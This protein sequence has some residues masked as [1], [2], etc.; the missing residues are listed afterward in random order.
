[1]L[2][3]MPL[4]IGDNVDS[5]MKTAHNLGFDYMEVSLD[6]PL[7]YVSEFKEKL[8]RLSEELDLNLAFHAPWTGLQPAH[9]EKELS[10]A[11]LEV[12]KRAVKF[13]QFL[14][15]LYFN[16][17]LTTSYADAYDHSNARN[18]IIFRAGEAASEISSFLKDRGVAG[19]LENACG[20]VLS[21]PAEF[22]PVLGDLGFCYDVGHGIEKPGNAGEEIEEWFDRLGG[23]MTTCHLHAHNGEKDHYTFSSA[24]V[25]SMEEVI[26]RLEQTSCDHL[27]LE[28]F[29]APEEKEVTPEL[30]EEQLERIRAQL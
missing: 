15:P 30:W 28:M 13:F 24:S 16:F 23:R 17:H 9:P 19:T 25:Y 22:A 5:K 10:L 29:Q 4:W 2:L 11:S 8:A 21:S 18:E 20:K 6:Y 1:M 12:M 7:I 3:G 26:E 27:L 14:S